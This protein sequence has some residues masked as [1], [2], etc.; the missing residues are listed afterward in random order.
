M[1]PGLPIVGHMVEMFRGGPDFFLQLYRKRGPVV[2]IDSPIIPTVAALGPDATQV[3]YSN[4]NK[5]YSQQGW[6]PVI[7]AFFNRGLMLLDFDEHMFHRRIMQEAFVRTR[8]AGYTEQVDTVVSQVIANDWVAN[9]A[10]FLLYPAMKELTLDIA[11]MVFMGHEPGSDHELVTKVNK[12]FT[13][14][15]RAGNAIIRNRV[16]PVHLV[17]RPAGPQAAGGL[18]RG[19]RQGA[20]RQARAPTC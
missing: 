7:E 1:T 3:I 17:A 15:T 14:T 13:T 20:P 12:A 10:R 16:P 2:L 19:A 18:L 4:R 9:D 6:A 11:S 8:L 5:E